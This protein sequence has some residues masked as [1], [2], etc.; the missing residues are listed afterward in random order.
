MPAAPSVA[1]VSASVPRAQ[2]LSPP[3]G[4]PCRPGV[5]RGQ[6]NFLDGKSDFE[7]NPLQLGALG[8]A[9]EGGPVGPHRRRRTET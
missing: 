1:S 8:V 2:V 7:T 3:P 5:G 6:Q 4:C 9:G